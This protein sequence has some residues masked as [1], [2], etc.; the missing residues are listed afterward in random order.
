MAKQLEITLKR[1]IIGRSEV[2]KA[3]VKT[4]GL[5]KINQT[6]V[7]ED[8]PAVRGMVNRVSHLVAVKEV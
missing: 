5:R 8:N 2:Q 6:V 7:R 4:L 3:T 1:S